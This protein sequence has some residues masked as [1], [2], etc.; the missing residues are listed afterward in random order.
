MSP[1]SVP[2]GPASLLLDVSMA[3][4]QLIVAT[5]IAR[6]S[7]FIAEAYDHWGSWGEWN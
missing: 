5:Q 2:L 6:I 1:L 7:A 3:P 4:P